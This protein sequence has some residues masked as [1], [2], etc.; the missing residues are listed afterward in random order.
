MNWQEIISLS[1]VIVTGTLFVFNYFRKRNKR[2]ISCENDCG[3]SVSQTKIL[4]VRN[5]ISKL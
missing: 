4:N 5:S 3:C 1:I 2:K